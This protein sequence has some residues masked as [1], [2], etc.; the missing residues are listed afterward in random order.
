[1]MGGREMV[2]LCMWSVV[3]LLQGLEACLLVVTFVLNVEVRHCF[4]VYY[5][6]VYPLLEVQ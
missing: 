4:V 1:M 6:L 5:Q 3:V 2:I